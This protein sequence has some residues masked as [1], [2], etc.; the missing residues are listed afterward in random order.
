MS[1]RARTGAQQG[2]ADR[3]SSRVLPLTS[4]AGHVGPIVVAGSHGQSLLLRVDSIPR[5]GETILAYGF[6]EPEDGGKATNQAV[7]AAKLGDPVRLLTLIGNDE[8]GDRWRRI[9]EGYGIDM[10]FVLE[11]SGATDVGFVMLPPSRIPA[12]ASSRDLSLALN[13]DTVMSAAAAFA[14]ASVV[15]C[16]LEAP[17]SCAIASFRLARAAG[18]MTILNPAPAEDLDPE[19]VSLTHVLVP[20]EHEAAALDGSEGAPAV[21]AARLAARFDCAIVVTAG[22]LGCYVE[23]PG[24]SGLHCPSPQVPV[25]DTTG[26]GDAFIGALA[27]RLRAGED[28]ANAAAFAV[29][30]ASISVTRQGTMPAYPVA[31]ELAEGLD[32][33]VS[34]ARS[35]Q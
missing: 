17:Q 21:L 20:N 28:L 30:A 10:R 6:E 33:A 22:A 5:E 7:A 4:A 23:A 2:Q 24:L 8:R 35:A 11:R 29:C 27:S 32:A 3:V 19:L 9:L 26:A 34:T 15:V 12:I 16:Q 31:A 25:A 14:D 18:A 13:S 1:E